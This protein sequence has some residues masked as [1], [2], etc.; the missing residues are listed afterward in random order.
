MFSWFVQRVALL[1][2]SAQENPRFAENLWEENTVARLS[3]VLTECNEIMEKSYFRSTGKDAVIEA[4]C[5]WGVTRLVAEQ[6]MGLNWGD[7]GVS[8]ASR[9]GGCQG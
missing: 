9:Q 3:M 7:P 1:S 8:Q 5:A 4:T 6:G 2:I